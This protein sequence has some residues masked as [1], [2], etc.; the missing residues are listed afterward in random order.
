MSRVCRN[1]PGSPSFAWVVS[2]LTWLYILSFIKI[3][4]GVSEPWGIEN[5]PSALV[6]LVAF[7][8]AY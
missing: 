6:W 7:T 1:H 8:T 5:L 2:A 3:H 4:S